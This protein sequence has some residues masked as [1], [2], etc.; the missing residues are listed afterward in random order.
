MIEHTAPP[1][2]ADDDPL[3]QAALEVEQ[4]AWLAGA[5]AEWEA[6]TVCDGRT[7]ARS[8]RR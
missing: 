7:A 8:R 4:N 3:Y 5:M 1:I 6:A 2:Q